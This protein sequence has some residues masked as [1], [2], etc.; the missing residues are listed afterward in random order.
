MTPLTLAPGLR[1][2]TMRVPVSKSHAHRVLIAEFLAGRMASLT[3]SVGDCDDVAATK[4]CLAALAAAGSSTSVVL[5]CGE[6]GTTRR[7]LGPVVAALGKTADWQMRG[8]LAARPQI[9]YETLVPGI[10]ELPGD[11]SS[12]F[13]S[14]LLFALPVLPG[15]S[16]IRLTTP[17][18]SRGY[19]DMTLDVLKTYDYPGNVRELL[20]ILDRARALEITD[21]RQLLE[22]H[23]AINKD[24]WTEDSETAA[25]TAAYPDDLKAAMKRHVLSVYDKYGQN[26]TATKNALGIS[27]NTL[28]KYL[29][30]T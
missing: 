5:D 8:R 11:V 2:G 6:S 1:T 29:A 28:K 15:A 27:L 9:A 21:F 14:G 20:N 4:R 7:L 17:L 23:K 16:E 18:A 30:K 19:V 10:Q 3:P 24:L 22:E 25:D 12:Q 26:L 13:V